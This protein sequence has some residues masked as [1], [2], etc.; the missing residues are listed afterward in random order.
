MINGD[1]RS[2]CLTE[3]LTVAG[4]N[5]VCLTALTCIINYPECSPDEKGLEARRGRFLQ[6]RLAK[7]IGF[8]LRLCVLTL[9]PIILNVNA[10][11]MTEL[12]VWGSGEGGESNRTRAVWRVHTAVCARCYH[13]TKLLLTFYVCCKCVCKWVRRVIQKKTLAC[14]CMCEWAVW[15]RVL[16]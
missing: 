1:K 13:K 9:D 2:W 10:Y 15:H 16:Y 3:W 12:W 7:K 4:C 14:M 6:L 8:F 11:F 5:C